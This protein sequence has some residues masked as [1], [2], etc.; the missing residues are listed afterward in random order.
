MKYMKERLVR[1]SCVA[2]ISLLCIVGFARGAQ[3]DDNT[4]AEKL[5]KSAKFL[6]E[7]PLDKN[8]NDL[9]SWAFE[10]IAQTE[11]VSVT[12]CSLLLE[13][14]KK[15]KYSGEIYIQYTIGMAAF[16]LANK[17]KAADEEAAQ[18]AGIESAMTSYEA[19]VKEKPKA[20]N[21]FMDSLLAKRTDGS[22]AKFVLE[23]NCK[24]KK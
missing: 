18:L 5:I 4:A 23:N 13:V 16:K 7:K 8:A 2:L 10:W 21:V 17:D 22:L 24:D 9:R 11:K 6:E 14:D 1:I 15:Y 19:I 12:V 3:D 20:T